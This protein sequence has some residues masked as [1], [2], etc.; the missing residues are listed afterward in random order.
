MGAEPTSAPGVLC[1]PLRNLQYQPPA[2]ALKR[3][4]ARLQPLP[5]EFPELR[6][7]PVGQQRLL[8]FGRRSPGLGSRKPTSSFPVDVPYIVLHDI[9]LLTWLVPKTR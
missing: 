6:M 7:L 1:L 2:E 9:D 4:Q 8:T 5:H 3:N